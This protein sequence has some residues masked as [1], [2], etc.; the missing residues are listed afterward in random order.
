MGVSKVLESLIIGSSV[1]GIYRSHIYSHATI[2]AFGLLLLLLL[3]LVKW[4]MVLEGLV[5]M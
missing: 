1:P 5:P 3:L 4:S 2:G